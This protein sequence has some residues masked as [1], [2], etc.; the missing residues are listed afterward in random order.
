M[1]RLIQLML[2]NSIR[3]KE[4]KDH[5]H[6]RKSVTLGTITPTSHLI[7]MKMIPSVQE[8][9]HHAYNRLHS[10]LLSTLQFPY[11]LHQQKTINISSLIDVFVHSVTEL[12]EEEIRKHKAIEN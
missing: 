2:N 8:H 11:H 1:N 6:S 5:K 9:S 12:T 3:G 10:W 4:R 7:K